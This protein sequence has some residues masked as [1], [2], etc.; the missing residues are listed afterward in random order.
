VSTIPTDWKQIEEV[1][2]FDNGS[3]SSMQIGAKISIASTHSSLNL[4]SEYKYHANLHV[5]NRKYGDTW[6]FSETFKE[7][8]Q[9]II[10]VMARM[11]VE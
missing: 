11:P 7:I 9:E 6:V 8:D 4:D 2:V 5:Y 10:N 1:Y 3:F